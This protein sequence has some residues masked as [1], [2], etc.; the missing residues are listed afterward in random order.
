MKFSEPRTL[1][2]DLK[3]I[4]VKTS[5]G[6]PLR[7][8]TKKCLSYGVKKS[9]KYGSKTVSMVLDEDSAKNFFYKIRYF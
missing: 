1:K 3:K 9:E 8:A 2:D 6:K 7:I 4:S 5:E